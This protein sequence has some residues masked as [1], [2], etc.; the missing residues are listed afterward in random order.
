MMMPPHTSDLL[1]PDGVQRKVWG[2]C[3]TRG[4]RPRAMRLV[5]SA[6]LKNA[7]PMDAVENDLI[8]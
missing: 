7:H 2:G 1:H 8:P 3:L 4:L 5:C 6:Y